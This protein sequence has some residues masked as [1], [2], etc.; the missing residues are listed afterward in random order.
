MNL[1]RPLRGLLLVALLAPSAWL[2][3]MEAPEDEAVDRRL[4]A[5]AEELRCLVCQN[6]SLADSD[7]DLAVSLRREIR[8]MMANGASDREVIDFLVQR[9]GDFVL[10]RPPLKES[11]WLLW[12]GPA[13][14]LVTGLAVAGAVIARRRKAQAPAPLSDAERKRLRA[15]LEEERPQ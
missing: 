5:L 13:L 7:A 6:Q 1:P 3:A 10:Y 8:E 2:H 9:Y 12:F 15:L 14:L 11:T 4:K